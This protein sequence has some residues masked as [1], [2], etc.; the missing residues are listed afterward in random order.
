PQM[1]KFNGKFEDAIKNFDVF[2]EYSKQK[3]FPEK[4]EF[5]AKAE[6]ERQG[7]F[8]AIKH[9]ENPFGEYELKNL[10]DPINS[11]YND[12]GPF[13]LENDSTI[14]LTSG[15]STATGKILDNRY[16]EYLSDNFRFT[17]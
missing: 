10:Q 1:Q 3:N 5:V 14:G 17:K 11:E 6:I 2:I 15:R 16:G 9:L 7:C 8:F 12:Y 13:I 4:K